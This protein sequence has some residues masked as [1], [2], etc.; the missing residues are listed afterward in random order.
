MAA[1]QRLNGAWVGAWG[2]DGAALD[3][4]GALFLLRSPFAGEMPGVLRLLQLSRRWQAVGGAA[5]TTGDADHPTL[6]ELRGL[7]EE[8]LK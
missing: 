4:C 8:R 6:V 2:A 7:I 1:G 5:A 3:D